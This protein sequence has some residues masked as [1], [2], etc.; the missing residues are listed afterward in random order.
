MSNFTQL[1]K[2]IKESQ[3]E[4]KAKNDVIGNVAIASL[5]GVIDNGYQMTFSGARNLLSCI[6]SSASRNEDGAYYDWDALKEQLKVMNTASKRYW[7]E[8]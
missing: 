5:E 3:A 7:S 1:L 6:I 8:E 2:D 4:E